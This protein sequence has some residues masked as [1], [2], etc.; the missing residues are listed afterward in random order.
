MVSNFTLPMSPWS[1]PPKTIFH[2]PTTERHLVTSW[3][4]SSGPDWPHGNRGQTK[5]IG[6]S[7]PERELCPTGARD[8]TLHRHGANRRFSNLGRP[9]SF[10]LISPLLIRNF[11]P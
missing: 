9:L 10:Q 4:H 3:P 6:G 5:G 1:E 11:E 8:V 7:F 2:K